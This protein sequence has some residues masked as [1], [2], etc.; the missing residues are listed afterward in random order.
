MDMR[1]F[2]VTGYA[3]Y[4]SEMVR[5]SVA[6]LEDGTI[7]LVREDGSNG[8]LPTLA[9]AWRTSGDIVHVAARQ[10]MAF[11]MAALPNSLP[12]HEQARGGRNKFKSTYTLRQFVAKMA[13]D[14]S[15]VNS[16][17]AGLLVSY[18][19]EEAELIAA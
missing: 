9:S 4:G 11:N 2:G 5:T 15:A 3:V 14:Q 7:V 16:I 10:G 19:V 6:A 18:E 8:I 12:A 13:S 1:K 17:V